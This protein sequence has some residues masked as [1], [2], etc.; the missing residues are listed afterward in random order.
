MD[1]PILS[2]TK[3]LEMMRQVREDIAVDAEQFEA[4][5]RQHP[6]SVIRAREL[7]L[8]SRLWT[9]DE[10]RHAADCSQC[11]NLV[12]AAERLMPHL[13][14]LAIAR[15]ILGLS[16]EAE[17]QLIR[18]HIDDGMCLRCQEQRRKLEAVRSA[19][20]AF[21]PA[22]QERQPALNSLGDPEAAL[23]GA[24]LIWVKAVSLDG[25]IKGTLWEAER[26]LNLEVRAEDA[27]LDLQMVR[28]EIQGATEQNTLTGYVALTR[29]EDEL[30]TGLAVVPLA[31]AYHTLK[32]DVR[33]V[34]LKPSAPETL[35][36][37]EQESLLACV[38]RDRADERAAKA[39]REWTEQLLSRENASETARQ[40]A[41]D[42]Q[43]QLNG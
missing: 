2:E 16:D 35:T 13:S 42:V 41:Q 39:W 37:E 26:N 20:A 32:A 17:Q 4:S 34:L 28:Y 24:D 7:A 9:D 36:Q 21:L 6:I 23:A 38:R 3:L 30:F 33:G 31:E 22:R 5:L 12:A 8:N 40:L 27:A 10:K 14:L 19:L 18:Y 43:T 29:A 15:G 1:E 25:R 11:R